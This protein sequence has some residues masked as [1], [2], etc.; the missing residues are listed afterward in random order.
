M[1]FKMEH[2]MALSIPPNRCMPSPNISKV[3]VKAMFEGT[4]TREWLDK[5]EDDQWEIVSFEAATRLVCINVYLNHNVNYINLT[6][7]VLSNSLL[8]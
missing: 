8:K 5:L 3:T 2:F 4:A 1:A 7:P 6:L